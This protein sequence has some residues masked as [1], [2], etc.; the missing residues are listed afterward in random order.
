MC[1]P[2]VSANIALFREIKNESVASFQNPFEKIKADKNA[3][4]GFSIVSYFTL[5]GSRG[6]KAENI[7]DMNGEL[8]VCIRLTK[9]TTDNGI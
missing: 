4:G 2:Y 6:G 7:L 8:D 1:M 3:I 5:M 9:C